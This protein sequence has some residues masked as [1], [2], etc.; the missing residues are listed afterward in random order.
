MAVDGSATKHIVVLLPAEAHGL[1][2]LSLHFQTYVSLDA[3][4]G[5]WA[6][7]GHQL[8]RAAGDDAHQRLSVQV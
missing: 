2:Y 7:R 8:L 1:F 3:P 5:G 4:H 6:G